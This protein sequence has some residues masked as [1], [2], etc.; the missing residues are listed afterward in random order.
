M[1]FAQA[2]GAEPLPTQLALRTISAE[3]S[4]ALWAV[5]HDNLSECIRYPENV[6]GGSKRLYDPWK[7]MLTAWW[8]THEHQN[9]D[10]FP[11]AASIHYQVKYIVTSKDYIKVFE[12]IQ[13]VVRRPECPRVLRNGIAVILERCRA[14]YRLIDNTIVPI[15][16]DEEASSIAAAMEIAENAIAQGPRVHLRKAAEALSQGSWPESV[17]ESIHAVE[18]A[19]RSI[20]PSAATLG[21][22]LSKLQQ[23]IALN[24]AMSRAFSSL[25]GYS[26]DEKGV[27]HA[28]VFEEVSQVEERDALFM[29]GACASFASYLLSANGAKR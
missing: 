20:E 15:T 9:I 21:P 6:Y 10:E 26:S 11:D 16:S 28:L 27:R 25:Y 22:A 24:P 1:T 23:S 13:F 14:S 2:E 7:A 17:R 18:A 5:I 4:A 3:L 19:A 29:L 12:F 8:V